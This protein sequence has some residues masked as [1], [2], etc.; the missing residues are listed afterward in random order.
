[1]NEITFLIFLRDKLDVAIVQS[2]SPDERLLEMMADITSRINFLS[3]GG[4]SENA[5]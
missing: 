2:G 4:T 5:D 1:M 3:T